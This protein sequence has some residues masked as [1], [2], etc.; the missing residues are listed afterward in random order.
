MTSRLKLK[1]KRDKTPNEKNEHDASLSSAVCVTK[2]N[3]LFE[4]AIASAKKH[5]INLKPGRENQGGGN[6]SYGQI[7]RGRILAQ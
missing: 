5:N 7:S 4:G 1:K 2:H 3:K 6:C